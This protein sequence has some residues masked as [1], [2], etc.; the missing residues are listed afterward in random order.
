MHSTPGTCLSAYACFARM[1]GRVPPHL[2]ELVSTEAA[3][4][5]LHHVDL[6]LAEQSLALLPSP[7]E[8]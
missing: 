4:K 3:D 2:Q 1:G 8:C 5:L 7:D 6:T